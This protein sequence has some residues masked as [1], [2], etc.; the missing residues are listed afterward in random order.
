MVVFICFATK[1]VHLEYVDDYATAGFLVAYKRFIS[2]R[3][4][5]LDMYSDNGTN[6]QGAERELYHA[7]QS[8]AADP[9]TKAAIANGNV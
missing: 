5:S 7:F 3:R 2:Y 9:Q 6:F 1:T 4:L 8:F